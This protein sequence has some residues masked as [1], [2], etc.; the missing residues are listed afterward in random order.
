MNTENLKGLIASE[1]IIVAREEKDKRPTELNFEE[2]IDVTDS[3]VKKLILYG[4]VLQSEQLKPLD[5]DMQQAL[6]EL[7]ESK[8][9]NK[10]TKKRF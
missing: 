9:G 6:N 5:A 7:T 1:L 8:V 2:L 3:I 10:P 4:V